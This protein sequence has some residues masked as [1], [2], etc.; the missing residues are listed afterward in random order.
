[1]RSKDRICRWGLVWQCLEK[2]QT[3]LKGS[4]A[5]QSSNMVAGCIGK[6]C[7]GTCTGRKTTPQ[8]HLSG[9]GQAHHCRQIC[10]KLCTVSDLENKQANSLVTEK[11]VCRGIVYSSFVEIYSCVSLILA[12]SGYCRK[13]GDSELLTA[14]SMILLTILNSMLGQTD[15]ISLWDEEKSWHLGPNRTITWCKA[16]RKWLWVTNA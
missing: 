13:G 9:K 11:I 7:N 1:M 2:T 15:A 14:M 10:E 5:N 6:N 4:N 3:F 16:N 12:Q 8:L